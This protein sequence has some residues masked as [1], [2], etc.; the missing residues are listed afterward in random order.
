MDFRQVLEDTVARV[1]GGIACVLM[2]RDGL[3]IDAYH[4]PTIEL[5]FDSA[6]FG[7]EYTALFHQMITVARQSN[8]GDPFEFLIRS[9]DLIAIFRF[10]TEDYFMLLTLSP[11]GNTGK[12]RYLLR[13]ASQ[14][15][16]HELLS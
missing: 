8:F 2:G 3:A 9:D 7:I 11:E 13:I 6:H 12:G 10:L 15:L 16:R 1:E 5:P 4:N 14:R